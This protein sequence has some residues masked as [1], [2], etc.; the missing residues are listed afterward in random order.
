VQNEDNVFGVASS[1]E[2]FN[3]VELCMRYCDRL[4]KDLY[5]SAQATFVDASTTVTTTSAPVPHGKSSTSTSATSVA[6]SS[7][8]GN[9]DAEKLKLCRENFERARVA[10]Q[11]TLRQGYER[12]ITAMQ[13]LL[14]EIL[15]V[16]LAGQA[17]SSSMRSI[18]GGLRFDERDPLAFEAQSA[19]TLLPKLLTLPVETMVRITTTGLSETNRDLLIGQLADAT[20][21]Q[22]EQFVHQTTFALPGALKLEEFVRL[23]S[24]LFGRHASSPI[25]GKFARL[26]EILSILTLAE[27]PSSLSA[28]EELLALQDSHAHVSA[29][30][31]EAFLLLRVDR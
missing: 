6:S 4:G 24:T 15:H 7:S 28:P 26:R 13:P 19:L 29:A 31:A 9:S 23:L 8:G 22:I 2:M 21:E 10:F 11:N 30:E 14:R 3:V 25:R 18:Y 27:I 1:V 20:C 12:L 5:A 17:P 16:T